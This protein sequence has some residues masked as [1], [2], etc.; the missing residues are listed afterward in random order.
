M[1]KTVT[2]NRDR[3]PAS[4]V[5]LVEGAIAAARD[6]VKQDNLDAIRRAT[7]ELQKASY[8]I[9]EQLY[10]NSQANAANAA[11]QNNESDDV[12]EGEVVDA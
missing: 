8:V 4:D 12:K 5:A 10:K 11:S 3:L 1:E 2:E 9:A 6:A 7:E